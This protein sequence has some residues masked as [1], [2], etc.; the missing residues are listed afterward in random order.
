MQKEAVKQKQ[1]VDK[2]K[3]MFSLRH[4]IHEKLQKKAYTDVLHKGVHNYVVS[5]AA[6][7]KSA[8]SYSPD[9]NNN[10]KRSKKKGTNKHKKQTQKKESPHRNIGKPQMRVY[11]WCSSFS[12]ELMCYSCYIVVV[13]AHTKEETKETKRAE[14]MRGKS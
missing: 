11:S 1:T 5:G 7:T 8:L 9:Q 13:K 4:I 14:Q 12:R 2:Q 3:K 10:K 6:R